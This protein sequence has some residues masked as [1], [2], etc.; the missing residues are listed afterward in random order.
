[1]LVP[2]VGGAVDPVLL[3]AVR[4]Y[5]PDYVV[6]LQ[7]TVG[8]H[9]QVQPGSLPLQFNGEE[10]AGA[11]RARAVD[12]VRDDSLSD[13]A[14]VRA[15]DAVAAVCSPHRRLD[16]SDGDVDEHQTLIDTRFSADAALPP[17]LQVPFATLTP[18]SALAGVSRTGLSAPADWG[19]PLGVMVAARCGLAEEPTAGED[20]ALD[21][22]ELRQL[23]DWLT[24]RGRLYPSA[25]P[26][27]VVSIP[28]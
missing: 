20:P 25:P 17:G 8:Q 23:V 5:D 2:H 14:G 11:E 10:L 1:M 18:L 28:S 3:Q 19:G 7:T 27:A 6:R 9:E 22:L 21:P 4:A 12:Q 16:G 26:S 15:R 24:D 13:L